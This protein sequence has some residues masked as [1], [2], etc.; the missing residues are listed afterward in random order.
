MKKL[1]LLMIATG[2]AVATAAC[3][4]EAQ[5]VPATT[6]SQAQKQY[7]EAYG[8]IKA[9]EVKNITLDFQAPVTAI[10]VK[11]GEK[12]KNGQKLVSLD[13]SEIKNQME[14][15]DL[16]LKAAETDITRNKSGIDLRKLQNDLKSA[17]DLYNKNMN[18]LKTKEELY[19]S[20][21]LSLSELDS[22]KKT[23]EGSKKSVDDAQFAIEGLNNSKGSEAIQKNLNASLLEANLNFLGS[24]LDKA[25][26]SGSDVVSDVGN[27][28]VYEIGYAKGDIAGPQK[29][30]LSILDLDSLVVE[31]N[32]PEEFI[33]NVKQGAEALIIPTADKT[34]EYKGK[35]MH[36]SGKATRNNGET[37]VAVLISIDGPDDFLLPEFN[38]DVKIQMK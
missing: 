37:L 7:V 9:L 31:A 25:Y 26:F 11:E 10:H 2:M 16:E 21:S 30:L 24:K 5:E 23:V 27:G 17:Q 6:Q 32:V 28:L 33:K 38:V 35:I 19:N 3:S 34:R 15:K 12:V 20:G 8:N 14:L 29:K 4:T 1:L 22:F 36:I 13:L 18:E